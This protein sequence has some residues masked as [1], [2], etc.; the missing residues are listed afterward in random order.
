[1]FLFLFC[2]HRCCIKK[3][4]V[5]IHPLKFNFRGRIFSCVQPSYEWAVSDLDMSMNI[6]LWVLVAHSSF[7]EGSHMTKNTASENLFR[8]IWCNWEWNSSWVSVSTRMKNFW[9]PNSECLSAVFNLVVG[10]TIICTYLHQL[11]LSLTVGQNKLGC[12][13]LGTFFDAS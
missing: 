2:W 10:P 4:M 1:M 9:C 5:L 12:L 6:F 8:S 7:T 11:F 13:S 3:V